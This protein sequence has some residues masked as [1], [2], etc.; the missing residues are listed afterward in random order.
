MLGSHSWNNISV[1]IKVQ[2]TSYAEVSG[3][4]FI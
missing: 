1:W 3:A 2:M 4:D